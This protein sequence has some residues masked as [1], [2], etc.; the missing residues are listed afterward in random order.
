V[1]E[2]LSTRAVRMGHVQTDENLADPLTKGI[3]K[4]EVHNTSKKMGL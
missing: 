2:L 3:A 4:K 1:R